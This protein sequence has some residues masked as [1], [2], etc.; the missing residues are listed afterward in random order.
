MRDLQQYNAPIDFVDGRCD[1]RLRPRTVSRRAAT[2]SVPV[3]MH[4]ICAAV[5]EMAK[6]DS[7]VEGVAFKPS[8]A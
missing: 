3:G 7:L 4:R 2:Q 5:F 1:L 6:T 8:V